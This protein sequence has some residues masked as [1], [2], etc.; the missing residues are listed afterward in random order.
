MNNIAELHY[1]SPPTGA[2]PLRNLAALDHLL[3]ELDSRPDHLPGIGVFSGPSGFGKSTA[4]AY[5]SAKHQAHYLEIRSTWTKKVFLENL[6]KQLGVSG[7]RTIA[8]MAERAAEE[9]TV[10]QRTLILDE[11]DNAVDRNL[12][13][14]VRDLYEQSQAA[15]ILIGEEQLPMKLQRWER[16]HGRILSWQQSIAANLED[17]QT[18]ARHYVPDVHFADDLLSTI[19]TLARG[20]VRRIVVNLHNIESFARN[21]G[22]E[23]ITAADWGKRPLITGNPPKVRSF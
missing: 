11:F 2:A 9:L 10:S 19:V 16:F 4:A 23:T 22:L 18:L 13:E 15:I 7:S 3:L 8:Q 6:L 14:L 21:S 12:I 20:S 5:V 1:N 17:A